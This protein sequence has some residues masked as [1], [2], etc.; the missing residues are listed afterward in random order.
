MIG[1]AYSYAKQGI[2]KLFHGVDK[3]IT[4]GK[5]LNP[6]YHASG[7]SSIPMVRQVVGDVK[8]ILGDYTQMKKSLGI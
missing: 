7:L 6:F 8:T 1:K 3:F 2:G 5:S 4:I